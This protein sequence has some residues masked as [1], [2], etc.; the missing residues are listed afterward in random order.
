MLGTAL[1]RETIAGSE[2]GVFSYDEPGT[3]GCLI[4]GATAPAPSTEGTLVYL[5]AG[6]SLDATLA[7][8]LAAG[9]CI[10]TPKVMLPGEMGCFAHI[11]DPEGNRV[12]LHAPH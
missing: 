10:T 1:R 6:A 3:G 9:G 5:D 7:R 12:G 2:L 8:V 4:A 11:T